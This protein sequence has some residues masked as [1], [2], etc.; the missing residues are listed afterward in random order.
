MANARFAPLANAHDDMITMASNLEERLRL[1]KCEKNGPQHDRTTAT[2]Y[3]LTL[4]KKIKLTC[5]GDDYLQK[6][7]QSDKN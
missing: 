2:S 3:Q 5:E 6:T 4:S 1:K 7:P